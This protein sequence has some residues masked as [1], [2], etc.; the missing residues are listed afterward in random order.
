MTGRVEKLHPGAVGIFLLLAHIGDQGAPDH[1]LRPGDHGRAGI[2]QAAIAV[3][4]SCARHH[5]A[6]AE[7]HGDDHLGLRLRHLLAHLGEMTAGEVAGFMRHH[8]DDL[9]WRLRLHHRTVVHE[10]AAAICDEGVK[11]ALVDNHDLDVL[12]FQPCRSQDRP[13]IFAQ[14]LLGLGIADYRWALGLLRKGRHRRHS[15][16]DRGGNSGQFRGFSS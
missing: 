6:G 10:N 4:A 5:R 2:G 15:K 12:L 1:F 16:R 9:V 11:N 14:Q 3:A 8:P 7:Q 13:G